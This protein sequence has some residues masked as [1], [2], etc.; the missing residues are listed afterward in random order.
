[1]NRVDFIKILE[2]NGLEFFRNGAKH[3]IFIQKKTGK[4]IPIP[5]HREIKNKFL[6]KV[7]KEISK[8]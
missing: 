3:D 2:Q 4:K 7:L 5:R 1:M 6:L 8:E